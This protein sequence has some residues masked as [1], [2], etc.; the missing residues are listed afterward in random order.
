MRNSLLA[1]V[2]V[3]GAV[4]VPL[5]VSAT[6]G[7]T[8]AVYGTVTDEVTGDPIDDLCV[9]V[10]QNGQE[11]NYSGWTDS[12]GVY[13]IGGMEPGSYDLEFVDCELG[14]YDS[15][16]VAASVTAEG[17]TKAD[18]TMGLASGYGLIRGTVTDADT[19]EGIQ[20][21]CAKVYHSH[22]DILVRTGWSG[23]DGSYQVRIEAGDYR[24]RFYPCEGIPYLEQWYDG[25]EGWNDSSVVTVT[26][27][28]RTNGIDAAMVADP[29]VPSVVWGTVVNG[30]NGHGVDG[31]CVSVYI[32]DDKVKTVLTGDL[33]GWEMEVEPGEYRFKAW[34]C[35]GATDLGHVW[36]LDAV[37]F[38]DSDVV[39]IPS[40]GEIEL[41]ELIVGEHRFRDSVHSMFI[42]DINW[43]A[44][45][46]I[47]LGC[48]SDA[49]AFCP[50][51][52]VTRA[53]MAAFLHRALAELLTPGEPVTFDDI[54]DSIF[55]ED[56]EWLASV[57]ITL[58][59]DAEGQLFCPDEKITR[60]QMAAFLHRALKDILAPTGPTEGFDDTTGSQFED[61]IAWLAAVGVTNGCDAEGTDFCPD[62][63]VIR[64]H[65]AAFLHRA[66]GD[67]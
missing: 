59:C 62:G 47:T 67:S 38:A 28:S 6:E 42:E 36:Y 2:L 26:S 31:Y 5:T 13:E 8:G 48:N 57:G 34:A 65:M 64:S 39:A 11:T 50:D 43:L 14:G 56:I 66:L 18:A 41:E 60:A 12:N 24:V 53:H 15:E 17:A 40:A 16:S 51:D 54:E 1:L 45:Q 10:T 3:A 27:R 52:L 7:G 20:Y 63:N 35:E 58:G 55:K 19:G 37:E 25:A 32:G 9:W 23:E 30:D 44:E 21:A 29:N 4:F 22:D 33:G 61:D 49:T 46:G